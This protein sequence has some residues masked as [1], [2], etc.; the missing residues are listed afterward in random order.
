[1]AAVNDD[2]G[3]VAISKLIIQV[4]YVFVLS[5]NNQQGML[6]QGKCVYEMK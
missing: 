4:Y 6:L 5:A 1:M 2:H 3:N